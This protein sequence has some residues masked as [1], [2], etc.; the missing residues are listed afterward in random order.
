MKYDLCVQRDEAL[1]HLSTRISDGDMLN[2][3]NQAQR[4]LN[5]RIHPKNCSK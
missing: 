4:S 3:W 1:E 5:G 2:V